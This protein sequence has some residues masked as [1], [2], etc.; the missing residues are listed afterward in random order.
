M[1]NACKN[2]DRIPGYDKSPNGLYSKFY[3]SHEGGRKP[4]VGEFASISVKYFNGKDS[5]MF[6]SSSIPESENGVLTQAVLNPTFKGGIEDA[7]MAMS[8]GDSASFKISA[9]SFYLKIMGVKDLP[10]Y[11]EKGSKLTFYMKLY[12]VQTQQELMNE[13]SSKEDEKRNQYLAQNNIQVQPTESG[14]YF[15]EKDPGKGNT[16][17]AGQTVNVKYTGMFL[18]GKIFDASDRHEGKPFEIPVGKGHVIKGWDE[19]LLKMKK[20][21][22]ATIILPSKLAYGP[23]GNGPIPAF[24]SLVFDLEVIDVK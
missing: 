18:N 1:F 2:G 7:L 24:T 14:L 9:D 11:I 6:N 20:G 8:V 15:I 12:K 13:L 3:I 19:A 10:K 4:K 23:Q 22:K 16:I 21:G 17:M 5:L